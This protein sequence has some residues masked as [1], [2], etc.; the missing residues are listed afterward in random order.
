M[1]REAW[2]L[3]LLRDNAAQAQAQAQ[4]LSQK[5]S[6]PHHHQ[7]NICPTKEIRDAGA[8]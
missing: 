5:L 7:R 3:L 1:Y 2:Q 4:N 8:S 6:F